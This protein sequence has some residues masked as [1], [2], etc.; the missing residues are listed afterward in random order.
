MGSEIVDRA[1]PSTLSFSLTRKANFPAPTCSGHYL[2]QMRILSNR[3]DNDL[4]I[5]LLKS[6]SLGICQKG[7]GPDYSVHALNYGNSLV[8]A[9]GRYEIN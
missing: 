6:R 3:R 9:R 2:A 4:L 8:I 7:G 5:V 1:I